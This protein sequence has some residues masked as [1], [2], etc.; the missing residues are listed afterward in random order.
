MPYNTNFTNFWSHSASRFERPQ[1]DNSLSMIVE[2]GLMLK[3]KR[4]HLGGPIG[5]EDKC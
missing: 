1:I 5:C 3:K 4:G 2:K